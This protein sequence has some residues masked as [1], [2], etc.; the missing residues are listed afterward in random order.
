MR[1]NQVEKRTTE[2]QGKLKFCRYRKM[3]HLCCEEIREIF[4]VA[5][6]TKDPEVID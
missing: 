3:A 5:N 4:V 1:I 2:R 6:D